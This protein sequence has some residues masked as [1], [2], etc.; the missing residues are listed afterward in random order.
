[1]PGPAV[2]S[3]TGPLATRELGGTLSFTCL[4]P[5]CART[6]P[7]T[8][9]HPVAIGATHGRILW[10]T[11][12][13]LSLRR[14]LL[15]S[16]G[17]V[18]RRQRLQRAS[19]RVGVACLRRQ[20]EGRHQRILCHGCPL[21]TATDAAAAAATTTAAPTAAAAATALTGAA[22]AS[23]PCKSEARQRLW[24]HDGSGGLRSPRGDGC[25]EETIG[26]GVAPQL[27]QRARLQ[28]RR[29]VWREERVA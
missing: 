19:L 6:R 11:S 18:V 8:T 22:A 9:T 23:S 12:S 15:L 13:H 24:Q 25:S 5:Q 20:P 7:A 2:A 17:A 27:E 28:R 10:H 26:F 14:L 4:S 21:V 16:G 3:V 1:M 29:V